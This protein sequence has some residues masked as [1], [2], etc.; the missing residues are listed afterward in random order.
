MA[1]V[2]DVSGWPI[3]QDESMGDSAKLWLL[4]TDGRRWMFTNS[5]TG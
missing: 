1:K 5:L 2:L 4:D 3:A